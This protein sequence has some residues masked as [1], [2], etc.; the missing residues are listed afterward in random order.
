MIPKLA[1]LA[2]LGVAT[3][4]VRLARATM[5]PRPARTTMPVLPV[6]A[7]T[8]LEVRTSN[9][10]PTILA[11]LR[12]IAAPRSGCVVC[13]HALPSLHAARMRSVGST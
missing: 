11:G 2:R 3:R 13:M 7:R 1:R 9:G 8:T 12:P 10:R 4:A 5:N 6:R